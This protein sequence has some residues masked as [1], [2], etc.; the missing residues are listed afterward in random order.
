[1]RAAGRLRAT[2]RTLAFEH[3]HQEDPKRRRQR[4]RTRSLQHGALA[5][6]RYLAWWREGKYSVNGTC[7]DIG[8][9]T[10]LALARIAYGA[11]AH[12]NGDDSDHASGN[13][14]IMRLAPV[15]MHFLDLFP[16]DLRLL[17]SYAEQSSAVTHGSPKCLS[18]CRYLA[19]VLAALM[20]GHKREE[21]LSPEW[22][23]LAD[24]NA[25]GPL[26]PM[27]LD[28]ARGSYRRK[29]LSEIRGSAYVVD[30]LEAA[31][32]AFHDAPT[33]RDAV[34]AAVNLGDDADTTGAI[35]GQLAGAYFGADGIPAEWLAGLAKR[36]WIEDAIQR[37][38]R[39]SALP[40]PTREHS[41][42]S[43]DID[44]PCSWGRG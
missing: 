5:A 6:H 34:F 25:I 19:V 1:M 39:P 8:N 36:E 23:V 35:C 31:L 14:S 32:W 18:A 37:L 38:G 10:R 17:A 33:F 41:E 30:S 15:P 11:L 28:V 20:A 43:Y 7:F 12:D 3:G 42:P 44:R 13:G 27:I 29:L 9:I 40:L 16:G 24:L 26:H 22:P 4:R 2:R 21:V